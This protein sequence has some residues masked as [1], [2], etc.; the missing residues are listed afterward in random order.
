VK[1]QIVTDRLVLRGFTEAY[2]EIQ[3]KTDV[4]P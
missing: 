4:L 1:Q 3:V 2:V